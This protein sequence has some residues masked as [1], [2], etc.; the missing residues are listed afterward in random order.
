MLERHDHVSILEVDLSIQW[1]AHALVHPLE[2][3]VLAAQ[4]GEDQA[5]L[6]VEQQTALRF[7]DGEVFEEDFV[8]QGTPEVES[9]L[10]VFS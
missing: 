7:A 1:V 5:S 8:G 6:F 4:V 3:A 9:V 10:V 2:S